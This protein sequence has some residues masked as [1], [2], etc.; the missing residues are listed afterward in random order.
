MYTL[1]HIK[2]SEP[3]QWDSIVLRCPYSSA[4]HCTQ[5]H[6]ALEASFRQLRAENFWI[7]SKGIFIGVFPCFT[8]QPVPLT[9]MLLSMPWNLSGGP[10]VIAADVDI[11]VTAMME[12]IDTQLSETA[13]K[14]GISETMIT[15]SPHHPPDVEEAL[16]RAGYKQRQELF[17]HLLKTNAD[18]EVLWNAYNKR[19]RGAVRKAEKCGVIV[20]DSDSQSELAEFYKIYLASMQR[21]KSTPKPF[22]LLRNLQISSIAKFTVAKYNDTIIAGLLYLFFNRTVTLWC[23]ASMPEFLEYRPNNA[24][25][26]HIIRWAC[27]QGYEWVDLGASPPEN[28]GLIAFKEQWR[29]Q[30]YNF[31]VYAKVHSPWKRRLWTV[32]EPFARKM[33][34]LMQRQGQ[35]GLKGWGARRLSR[36]SFTP[37]AVPNSLYLPYLLCLLHVYH[38]QKR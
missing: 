10:L 30:R 14:R 37:Q 33:Y 1:K 24:I 34:A 38:Y 5:W 23:G 13:R 8:F 11:D 21:F 36:N 15:L 28:T 6:A 32:A 16:I 35:R 19:I 18:Y 17:T 3:A 9:K 27:A 26:H 7:E 4:F 12:S 20:H 2:A 31:S 22:S 25:F 29:A